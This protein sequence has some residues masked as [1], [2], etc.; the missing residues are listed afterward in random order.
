MK[1]IS[2]YFKTHASC[3]AATHF[4]IGMGIG[5]MLT[6]P[7]FGTHPIRWG[8]ALVAAGLI[9]YLYPLALKK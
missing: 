9:G 4:F 3:N 8:L 6:F 5:I 7:Y 2:K 1:Q